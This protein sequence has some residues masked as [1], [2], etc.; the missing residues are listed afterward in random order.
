VATLLNGGFSGPFSYEPF[1]QDVQSLSTPTL[2][3]DLQKSVEYLFS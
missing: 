1:S 3:T 2:K